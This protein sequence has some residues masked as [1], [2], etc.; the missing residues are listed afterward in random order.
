MNL[1]EPASLNQH[2]RGRPLG[3]LL[4]LMA[5][6]TLINT[7][8][9]MVYPF[10]PVFSRALDVSPAVFSNAIAIRSLAGL[11]SPFLARMADS[12]GRKFGMGMGMA[13]FLAG[14]AV[15]VIVPTFPGFVVGLG[16]AALGK[17][18]LDPAIHAYISDEVVIERRGEA[19]AII[20]L[21]WSLS[22]LVGVRAVRILLEREG[23]LAPFP[24]MGLFGGLALIA[25]LVLI[26]AG[27]RAANHR[28]RLW[29]RAK[30]ILS[31][32]SARYGLLVGLMVSAANELVSLT[33][34]VWLE[35]S[36]QVRL[37]ALAS[38]AL[39]IGISELIGESLVGVLTDR[40]GPIRAVRWG[41]LANSVTVLLLPLVG[42]TPFG[43]YTGLF[44]FYLSFEFTLVSSISM[45]TAI[46]SDSRATLMGLNIASL[47]IGRM[48]SAWVAI[49]IYSI[50]FLLVLAGV[51]VFNG[52]G[53]FGLGRVRIRASSP[54]LSSSA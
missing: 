52:I 54:S 4:L 43:A 35:D 36:F 29:P 8:H 18:A 33:F 27:V 40:L 12:R 22:Y 23:W 31:V 6:R 21:G 48:F 44:L 13:F 30:K 3:R 32:R 38:A 24:A 1:P 34:A 39:V 51:F 46:A 2:R 9:R 19:V 17:Y 53:L 50:S 16:L 20:E 5:V 11:T 37:A 14:I 26:P 45:M 41:I 42:G 7:L 25:I 10:L 15:V 49:P 47:S 28:E